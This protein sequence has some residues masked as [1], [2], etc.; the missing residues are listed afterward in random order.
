MDINV[1]HPLGFAMEGAERTRRKGEPD[2]NHLNKVQD[3]AVPT[4]GSL[5]KS[6]LKTS[7]FRI[8]WLHN[9]VGNDQMA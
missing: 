3:T 6:T 5:L 2:S 1:F 9:I 8:G 7:L 4:Q